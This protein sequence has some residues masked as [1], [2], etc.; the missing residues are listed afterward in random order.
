MYQKVNAL[1]VLSAEEVVPLK[2]SSVKVIPSAVVA[3]PPEAAI[4]NIQP[5]GRPNANHPTRAPPNTLW[6]HPGIAEGRIYP[7]SPNANHRI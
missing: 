1:S 7:G 4:Y 5:P 3:T 6:F 2:G